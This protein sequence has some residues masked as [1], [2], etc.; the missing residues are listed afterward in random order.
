MVSPDLLVL[1]GLR[2]TGW[3]PDRTP[4]PP[5]PAPPVVITGPIFDGFR[6]PVLP[7]D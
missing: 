4:D 2:P 5:K 1:I 3:T 7:D 6:H